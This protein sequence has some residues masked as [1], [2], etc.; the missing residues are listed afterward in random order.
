MTIARFNEGALLAAGFDRQTV[1]VLRHLL[2]QV[3]TE[4]GGQTL[5]QVTDQVAKIPGILKK[6]AMLELRSALASDVIAANTAA[7]Q[8][9][10]SLTVP[11]GYL[12]TGSM[13]SGRVVGVTS[14]GTTPGELNVW[15]AVNGA[16]VLTH[17]F[18][19]PDVIGND[20]GFSADFSLIVRDGGVQAGGLLALA[21]NAPT[22]LPVAP[23]IAY[24]ASLANGATFTLGMHW[25]AADA[26]NTATA[27]I[28]S[29]SVEKL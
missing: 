4:V 7:E 13:L 17:K 11:G 6:I 28:A 10:L 29:L 9:V 19:T 2:Q 16:K 24:A 12:A 18:T 5:P 23:A 8:A 22:V 27:K 21:Y 20:K 14:N 1:A 3:G 25:T 26:G 15:L